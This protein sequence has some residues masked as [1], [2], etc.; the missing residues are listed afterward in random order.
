[1]KEIYAITGKK[2]HGKDTFAKLV[3]S[4]HPSFTIIH[5][6]DRLKVISQ[7]IFGLSADQVQN[8]S[9]KEVPF[10]EPIEMD[11]YLEGM[12]SKTGLDLQPAGMVAH[13]PREIMQYLGTEYV[14]KVQRDYWIRCAIDGIGDGRRVLIPDTRF[15]NEARAVREIRG[16]VIRITRVDAPTSQDAHDSETELDNITPDLLVGVRTGDLTLVRW[17][18]ALVSMGEFT[19]A[20]RYDYRGVEAALKRYWTGIPDAECADVLWGTG[21]RIQTFNN[22]LEYYAKG[23]ENLS[24]SM[25]PA[26]T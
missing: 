22:V 21:P 15:L 2:G 26:S 16:Y 3:Q 17:V 8:P 19:A 25:I 7:E 13:S 9:F 14:R 5:F 24:L 12:R 23:S 11:L 4:M 10:P 18:A 1:M 20:S 6:A